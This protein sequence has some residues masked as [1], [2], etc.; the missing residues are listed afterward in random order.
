MVAGIPNHAKIDL[1]S[2][3]IPDDVIVF[4][5]CTSTNLEE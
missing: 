2:V 3:T 1:R 5:F 4:S